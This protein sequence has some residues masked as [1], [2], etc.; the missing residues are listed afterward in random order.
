MVASRNQ[1]QLIITDH[2]WKSY[3]KSA[4][5][6]DFPSH[7]WRFNGKSSTI[8]RGPCQQVLS[9]SSLLKENLMSV[10]NQIATLLDCYVSVYRIQ[11]LLACQVGNSERVNIESW[12]ALKIENHVEIPL[13]WFQS[14]QHCNMVAIFSAEGFFCF[15]SLKLQHFKPFNLDPKKD[16]CQM[17][18]RWN[19]RLMTPPG[20]A[21]MAARWSYFDPMGSMVMPMT[22]HVR[23]ILSGKPG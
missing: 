10:P 21:E 1:G 17:I 14:I 22:N 4:F 2:L 9:W 6:S 20:C 11:Q 18:W 19:F 16:T 13:V 23:G 15:A 7:L 8:F 5:Q 12:K 3:R